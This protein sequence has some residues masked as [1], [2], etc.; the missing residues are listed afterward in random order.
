MSLEERLAF[1]E[2]P[3]RGVRARYDEMVAAITT[4]MGAPYDLSVD[5]Q[6]ECGPGH[7]KDNGQGRAEMVLGTIAR[8][9]R[10]C[11][12]R[13]RSASARCIAPWNWPI[14]QLAAKIGPALVAGCTMVLKPQRDRAAFGAAASPN[15]S[16]RQAFPRACSTWSTAPAQGIGDALTSHPEADMVSFTGS[17]R[18]GVQVAK[19]RRR[20]GQACRQE[21]GGKSA[22]RRLCG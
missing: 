12:A 7:L 5:A 10:R 9:P 22:E 20:H 6:A 16:T 21:L 15:S 18:A 3:D 2:P 8:Q 4:E 17:T 19:S 1:V 13:S 11:R 14:N